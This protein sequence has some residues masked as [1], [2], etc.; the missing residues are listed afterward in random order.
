MIFY[1][2]NLGTWGFLIGYSSLT[3]ELYLNI[4]SQLHASKLSMSNF[5]LYMAQYLDQPTWISKQ[6][7]DLH[8]ELNSRQGELSGTELLQVEQIN[9]KDL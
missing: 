2:N 9:E 7:K 6:E 8:L 3:L 1:L 4:P 5:L